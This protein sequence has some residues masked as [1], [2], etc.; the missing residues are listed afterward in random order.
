MKLECIVYSAAGGTADRKY[1]SQVKSRKQIQWVQGTPESDGSA[2]TPVLRP[3]GRTT[4]KSTTGEKTQAASL[5]AFCRDLAVATAPQQATFV[6]S[7]TVPRSL[8]QAAFYKLHAAYM[9]R[10]RASGV[11]LT[12]RQGKLLVSMAWRDMLGQLF[13][14]LATREH[15]LVWLPLLHLPRLPDG[16][17]VALGVAAYVPLGL[18]Q[19]ECPTV[20]EGI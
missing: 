1:W 15:R 10:R 3:R 18:L 20:G 19:T 2:F 14:M 7:C 12:A 6:E 5:S 9:R 8:T 17:C 11:A 16:C 13:T 4:T